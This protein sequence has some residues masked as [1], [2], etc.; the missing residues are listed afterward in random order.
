M[1][2]HKIEDLLIKSVHSDQLAD[3]Y[4]VENVNN[5]EVFY[6]ILQIIEESE[7]GDAQMQG[8]YWLSQYDESLLAKEE[9]RLLPLMDC[10]WDSISTHIMIALSKIKS[11]L[12]LQKIIENR[13]YPHL[14]WEAVALRNY[15]PSHGE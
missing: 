11:E 7:S 10:E 5:P 2:D 15:F 14:Y 9:Q 3:Q 12:A 4:F 6:N 1:I 8:A 13:I